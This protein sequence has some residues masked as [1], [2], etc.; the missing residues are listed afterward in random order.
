MNKLVIAVALATTV[1]SGCANNTASGDTF[2]AS[3]A[4]QVQTVTYG[5]IVSAR[6]V[7]IQGG[8]NNNVAGA[9]GGAVVGGFLGNT[10]GGGRG[11]SLATAGGA[12]AGGVA[13]QGIQSAMNRSEGVQLEIR[14][15]DGSNIVVVQAQG[16]TRFSAGQRVMIASDRSGTVTVSPR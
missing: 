9:I 1:L 12:V 7:T 13:G 15:D 10:I 14:R 5:S 6:P 2:T 3:Q 8:N 11:N 4:R 16:P